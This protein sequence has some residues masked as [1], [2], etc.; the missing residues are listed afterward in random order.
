MNRVGK[1]FFTG[2]LAV[3][4]LLATIYLIYW[5]AATTERAAGRLA[6]AVIGEEFYRPGMGTVLALGT[7]F[8]IGLM[9]QAFIVRRLFEAWESLLYRIP[10]IR[11]VYRS[12]KE[13]S[14][15]LGKSREGALGQV[16]ACRLFEGAG[17]SI[18]FVTREKPPE[19]LSPGNG[20]QVIAVYFPLSYQIGGFTLLIPANR[21]RPVNLSSDEAMRFVITGGLAELDKKVRAPVE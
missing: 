11:T 10:V 3:L 12:L 13:L 1:T 21:L 5:F 2:L 14:G 16:V 7:I 8:V 9:L 6:K 17:E 15:Y 20:E 19:A 4:P 18:G